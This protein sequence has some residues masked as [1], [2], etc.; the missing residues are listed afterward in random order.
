MHIAESS[1]VPI[2]NCAIQAVSTDI[3]GK[4]NFALH[5][6]VKRQFQMYVDFIYA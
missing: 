3:D 4:L 2:V 6:L 1:V 5:T